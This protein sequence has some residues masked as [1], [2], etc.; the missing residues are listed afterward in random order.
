MVST[1]ITAAQEP[2]PPIAKDI[3]SVQVKPPAPISIPLPVMPANM[4]IPQQIY[5]Q[6]TLPMMPPMPNLLTNVP[7][8]QG[9]TFPVLY[10]NPSITT[11]PTE[12]QPISLYSEYMGN[13]YNV[14]VPP[15]QPVVTNDNF[16]STQSSL[17]SFIQQQINNSPVRIQQ[18]PAN[19]NVENTI[20]IN[21]GNDVN[22]NQNFESNQPAANITQPSN[23]FQSSNY[24]SMNTN[25]GFIPP[26]SEMLFGG[27]DNMG[28][29]IPTV[30]TAEST[31]GN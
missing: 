8:N 14:G 12:V 26:G 13:P 18:Q 29:N 23:F 21:L 11:S 3:S 6:P 4:Q 9:H 20:P 5:Q 2:P 19:V 7:T 25:Q 31:P 27:N 17:E 28:L 22:K 15:T 10:N 1:P 30:T 16:N 24:F